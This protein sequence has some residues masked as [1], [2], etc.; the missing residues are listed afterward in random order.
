MEVHGS[1]RI[2]EVESE[3]QVGHEHHG[4]LEPLAL[5]D[6]EDADDIVRLR[7]RRRR[8]EVL[9]ALPELLDEV[10]EP[11]QAL[12]AERPELPCPVVQADQVC[13]SLP[14]VRQPADA[15]EVPGILVDLPDYVG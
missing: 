10:E 13:P 5:V 9:P 2:D 3:P 12:P 4:E 1:G 6:A 14:A 8:A 11:P 7:R 15:G